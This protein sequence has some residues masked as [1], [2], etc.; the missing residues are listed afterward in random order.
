[1][2]TTENTNKHGGWNTEK[3]IK[4]HLSYL[5]LEVPTAWGLTSIDEV[6]LSSF[7]YTVP[8]QI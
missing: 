5:N 2:Y 6:C 7:L 8:V 3:N 1:M 4:F